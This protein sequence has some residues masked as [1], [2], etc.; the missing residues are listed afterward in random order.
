MANTRHADYA[1]R[2]YRFIAI[3]TIIYGYY[4]L[5]AVNGRVYYH[6]AFLFL[7]TDIPDSSIPPSVSYISYGIQLIIKRRDDI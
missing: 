1:Y 2:R 5:V 3:I 4:K 6:L 7:S